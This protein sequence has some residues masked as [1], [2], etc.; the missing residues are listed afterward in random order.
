MT[1]WERF[2]AHTE[3]ADQLLRAS[4]HE[5][6]SEALQILALNL[7]AYTSK[8]GEIPQPEILQALRTG[9]VDESMAATLAESI[10]QLCGVLRTVT[11][12]PGETR[13]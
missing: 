2:R 5:Q 13:N 1:N 11:M 8:Y 7:A 3:L 4:T 9:S 6:L 10:S 12:R